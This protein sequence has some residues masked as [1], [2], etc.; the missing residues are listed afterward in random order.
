MALSSCVTAGG[1][2]SGREPRAL[3]S[4][5]GTRGPF[6]SKVRRFER[7]VVAAS[8]VQA[9]APGYNRDMYTQENLVV[10]VDRLPAA[11]RARGH[12]ESR[13]AETGLPAA[14][15]SLVCVCVVICV[16]D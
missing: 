6:S 11:R 9:V 12:A 14:M 2:V 3:A 16:E 4:L 13:A 1:H 7:S 15:R 10:R 5:A 8:R